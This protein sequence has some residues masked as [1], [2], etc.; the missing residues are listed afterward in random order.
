VTAFERVTGTP[1]ADGARGSG[2][3]R[4]VAPVAAPRAIVAAGAVVSFALSAAAAQD[5]R[6][7][8]AAVAAIA[9]VPLLLAD[10][11]Y[12]VAAFAAIAFLARL[13]V[14]GMAQTALFALLVVRWWL[15]G[16]SAAAPAGGERAAGAPSATR[17]THPALV[18]AAAGLL[19]WFGLTLG[20]AQQLGPGQAKLGDWI[21]AAVAAGIVATSVREARH[22]RAVLYAY[23]AGA[24]LSVLISLGARALL[25]GSGLASDTWFDGRLQGGSGDPNFLAAGLVAAAVLACG[26]LAVRTRPAERRA[27]LVALAVLLAGIGASASR[28]GLLA[29][30]VAALI[31]ILVPGA[32]RARVGLALLAV[33]AVVVG[34]L[35]L[36]PGGVQHVFRG[37][38][39]GTG[40]A[41]LWRVAGRMVAERPVTGIGLGNFKVR[42]DEF[43]REPGALRWVELIAERPHEAHNTY[44]QLAAETGILGLLA[45]LAV[46]GLALRAGRQAERRFR[47]AGGREL[48]GIARA[49]WIATVAVLAALFF[50]TDGDDVRLWI[51]FGLAPALLAI[52]S[53]GPQRSG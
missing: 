10:L 28:G 8:L 44:L 18:A 51:L 39:E 52:A 43:V 33:G 4:R 16:R 5:L 13:P 21:F 24:V 3:Q 49:V 25:P 48:A 35:A 15:D 27:L 12:G 38:S 6:L 34:A 2:W 46:T 20:W 45:F 17:A 42:E 37:D 29:G 30:I 31:A 50:L 9:V 53:R 11:A 22:V 1:G 40:R 36:T 41:E 32:G 26:L 19:L 7:G 23:I 14:V 47:A